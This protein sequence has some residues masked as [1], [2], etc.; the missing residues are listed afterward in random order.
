MEA[1]VARDREMVSRLRGAGIR[2]GLGT[3]TWELPWGVH[4]ELEHLV[5]SG[6]TPL[7]AIH[8]ATGASAEI[9]GAD[10]ELGTLEEGKWADLV[11]LDA[12]PLADIRNTRRIHTVV[13]GGEVVDRAAIRE[14]S[15]GTSPR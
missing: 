10:E 13:K 11:L 5:R 3:D 1:S 15:R 9:L 12:D 2:I 8:A 4:L 7:E 14:L 6:L